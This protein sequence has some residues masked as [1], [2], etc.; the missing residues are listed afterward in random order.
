[1]LCHS[2]SGRLSVVPDVSRINPA[3]WAEIGLDSSVDS[4]QNSEIYRGSL[5][6]PVFEFRHSASGPSGT[7]HRTNNLLRFGQRKS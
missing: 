5:A 2:V 4:F 3:A 1:M 6:G 7:C